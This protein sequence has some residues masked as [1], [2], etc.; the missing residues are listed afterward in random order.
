MKAKLNFQEKPLSWLKPAEY[1]PRA[2]LQ[3]G[4]PEYEKIKNSIGT[5]DYVDPIIA[6]A[7]GTIISGHQRL[8]VLMDLGYDSADVVIV[9][10]SKEE[11]KALNIALNK[12]TGKWD[13]AKLAEVIGDI[14][15]SGLDATLTG[16]DDDQIKQMVGSVNT[17][18]FEER[19][20]F[21]DSRQEGN[22][23]YNDFLEK[24]EP[25]KTTDDCYTPDNIYEAVAGWVSDEYGVDKKNFVRP[26]FPGGDYQG[27]RYK[28]SDIVV[29]NPPFSILSEIIN[30]YCDRGIKYFLFAP[31]MTCFSNSA[32][33]GGAS[34]TAHVNITYENGADV[35]TA[36]CT[37]LEPDDVVARTAP[38]LFRKV[39]E[40]NNENLRAMKAELPKYH[41]PDQVVTAAIMSR[42]SK[43]GVDFVLRRSDCVKI[44][45]LD[46]QKEKGKVI[47]GKGFLLSERAAAERAA[48]ER[49]AAERAAAERWTLSEREWKIVRSLG[50]EQGNE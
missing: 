12:I 3:P 48:A 16:F 27:M 1:N 37:N 36:F 45:A 9:D 46:S 22:D 23:E 28:A 8:K 31:A 6:N 30:F 11:E 40:V 19:E 4:D 21:D 38:D 43:Y 39:E 50:E 35:P 49:A 7:D 17:D 34:I 25:K 29:D 44:D 14:D 10:K 5:L 42:W 13:P 47:F 33:K 24:F 20:R 15:V 41:Y 2:D 26:F 32:S 18:W